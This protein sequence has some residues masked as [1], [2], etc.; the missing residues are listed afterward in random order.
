MVERQLDLLP[1]QSVQQM[2]Q[3]G[4][5]VAQIDD[6]ELQFLLPRERQKLAHKRGGTV[7]ILRNLDEIPEIGVALI[8]AQQQ[9]VAM[10]R[11]RG[12]QVVEVMRHASG[13]LTHGLH[14]LALDELLFKALEFG[15]VVQNR[16][17]RGARRVGD[18]A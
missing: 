9:Q 2:H 7:G 4:H 6:F 8:V 12:Q 10:A 5:G 16:Q 3:V 1:H 15:R 11:D 13:K 17:E 14:F 18:T